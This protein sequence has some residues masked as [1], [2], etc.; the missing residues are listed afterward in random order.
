MTFPPL[1]LDRARFADRF[2]FA[3]EPRDSFLHPPPID[4]QLRLTRAAGADSTCLP[5]QVVPHFS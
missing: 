1:P 3:L 2:Q 4:F 5:R